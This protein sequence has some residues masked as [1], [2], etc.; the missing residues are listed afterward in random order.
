MLVGGILA[1]NHLT[2]DDK[3]RLLSQMRKMD[4][5]TSYDMM[6]RKGTMYQ[7]KNRQPRKMLKIRNCYCEKK[8]RDGFYELVSHYI[9]LL[10]TS[11]SPRDA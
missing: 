6:Q 2:N 8:F 3:E 10:Y 4:Y 1:M 5:V 11:P 9:C 7:V